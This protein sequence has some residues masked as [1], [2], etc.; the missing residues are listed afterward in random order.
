MR[1]PIP[2]IKTTEHDAATEAHV[3]V[4]CMTSDHVGQTHRTSWSFGPLLRTSSIPNYGMNTLQC[5]AESIQ[6]HIRPPA[7]K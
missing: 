3:A 6:T 5:E 2:T 1:P 7:M 4:T